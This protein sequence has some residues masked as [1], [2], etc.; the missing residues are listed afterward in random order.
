M[1]LISIKRVNS[2]APVR[3]TGRKPRSALDPSDRKPPTLDDALRTLRDLRPLSVVATYLLQQ[4]STESVAFRK[5]ADVLRTDAKLSADVLRITN[6][7]LFGPRF[8]VTGVL[9]ALAMLGLDRIRSLV[10]TA[11]LKH[12][13]GPAQGAPALV[14]CW[15]HN[16]A[17]AFVAEEA[18][19]NTG[20]D[21]DF[22]YTA[23]LLHDIGRLSMISAWR[24]PYAALLDTAQLDSLGLLPIERQEF[25][26]PHTRAGF[27]LL[28]DW[29]LP[30]VFAEIADRHHDPPAE[31]AVDVLAVV[32]FSC[33][34]ADTLGFEVVDRPMAAQEPD[35]PPPLRQLISGTL[36]DVHDRVARRINTLES[37]LGS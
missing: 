9:H 7:A 23:G 21:R 10:T 20:L 33:A 30:A 26:I 17:C 6:S 22:A 5:I 4:V 37:C 24:K 11:A 25:G 28:Q 13:I 32:Q 36:S 16:L 35:P 34:F 12:L 8:P 18:V 31:G 15:R 2:A 27:A 3:G 29:K 1:A 19:R 14:R